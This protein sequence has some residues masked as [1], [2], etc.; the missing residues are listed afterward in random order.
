MSDIGQGDDY[1]TGAARPNS[2]FHRRPRE[3]QQD[4][5]RPFS[6]A[7]GMEA[8]DAGIVQDYRLRATGMRRITSS[9]WSPHLQVDRRATGFAVWQPPSVTWTTNTN[10]TFDRRNLQVM[11]FII[12][13]IFPFAWMIA[14]FL[15]LPLDPKRAMEKRPEGEYGVPSTLKQRVAQNDEKRYQSARWWRNLNRIMAVF[16]L[17]IIGAVVAL[18]VVG[19]RQGW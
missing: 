4:G 2:A 6:D 16:G 14:A 18:V 7:A 12:G 10:A 13:F 9:I 11:S 3:V 19:V 8:G 17:L 5:Y 15:P 1:M